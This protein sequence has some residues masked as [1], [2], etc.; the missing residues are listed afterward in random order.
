M[1]YGEKIK[2][3]NQGTQWACL[4]FLVHKKHTQ[5]KAKKKKKALFHGR[6]EKQRE[7]SQGNNRLKEISIFV[8]LLKGKSFLWKNKTQDFYL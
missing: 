2:L 6:R 4:L 5:R 7:Q 8:K 1:S 3:L